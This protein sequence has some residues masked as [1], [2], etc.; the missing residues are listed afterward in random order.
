M[1]FESR[2]ARSIRRAIGRDNG[3][4]R[5]RNTSQRH[6]RATIGLAGRLAGRPETTVNWMRANKPFVGSC[7]AHF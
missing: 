6:T 4:S 7:F 2:H 5:A 1:R 3:L